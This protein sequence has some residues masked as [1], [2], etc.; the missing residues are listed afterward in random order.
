MQRTIRL[1]TKVLSHELPTGE[2]VWCQAGTQVIDS[3]WKFIKSH[4]KGNTTGVG[5]DSLRRKVR[6][7]QWC[8]WN[9]GAGVFIRARESMKK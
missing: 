8:Y 1:F 2:T 9:R 5:S 3:A 7:A 6:S 4:M